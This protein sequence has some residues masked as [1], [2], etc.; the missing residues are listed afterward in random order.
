[1]NA[2]AKITLLTFF[3]ALCGT[4]AIVTAWFQARA[5]ANVKPT[6]LYA[7]VQHQLGELRGGNFSSAY[8]DASYEIQR[9]FSVDQFAAMVQE[10]YPGMLHVSRAQ[11]GPVETRGS[12]ATIEV[13]LIGLDG[14]VMPCVYMMVHEGDGWR[15]DGARL[16]QPW[17]ADMHVEGEEL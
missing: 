17:P 1:M 7:V 4:A 9:R 8:Q 11:Y 10:Q 12:H 14:E 3:F 16:L 13:Y 5:D 15:I 2:R 6:V